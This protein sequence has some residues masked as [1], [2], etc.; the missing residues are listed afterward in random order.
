[1]L[2]MH[3]SPSTVD[4]R[5]DTM[6]E[7]AAI[8]AK[9][10]SCDRAKVGCVITNT[11]MTQIL[12][13]G[14]NG[15][16]R[17]GPNECD[18]PNAAGQCGCIHAEENA[19]IKAPYAPGQLLLFSTTAPCLACAKLI[20]NAGIKYVFADVPYRDPSGIELLFRNQVNVTIRRI[21]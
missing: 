16:Y 13:M 7:I 21:Q 14:Y 18:H 6:F 1:M 2:V 12:A 3:K 11:E 9:R 19:L 8:I 15:N 10:S 17:G 20:L 4:K 5:L